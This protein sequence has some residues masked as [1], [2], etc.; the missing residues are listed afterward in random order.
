M[1]SCWNDYSPDDLKGI[2]CY[3]CK[4]LGHICC[5]DYVST[6]PGVISCYKC[7][8]LG[9]TGLACTKVR[10]EA[11]GMVSSSSCYKCGEEGHFA[12]ECTSSARASKRSRELSTPT[13]RFHR[14]ERDYSEFKSLPKDLGKVRKK[15]TKRNEEQGNTTPRKSKRRGGQIMEYPGDI[16]TPQKSK[17]RGGW[18][19]E[20]P[21]DF[22]HRK[23]KKNSWRS[24][25]TPS[26]KGHT[27]STLTAG[28]HISSSRASK[29]SS[30][31]HSGTSMSQGS[32]MA[33]QH[34]FSA[35]RFDNSG[36]AGMQRSYNW[37]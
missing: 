31:F 2:Q 10:G 5:V 30:N 12:R 34:R 23:A 28:G 11:N 18:I 9:H 3:I 1:F 37:W 26:N 14:E 13:L 35:S 4:R 20:D 25:A 33:F 7:G 19:T 6:S 16:S 36:G 15:K 21:G 22:S 27:I 8:Q 24:P 32:P 29:K 17:H